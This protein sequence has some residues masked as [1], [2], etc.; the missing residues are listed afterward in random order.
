VTSELFAKQS[1]ERWDLQNAAVRLEGGADRADD[2]AWFRVTGDLELVF[3]SD[4]V[5]GTEFLLFELGVL[6]YYDVG[7]YLAAA[8]I[9]DM[10]AMGAKPIALTSVIRYPRTL[11]DS[12]FAEILRGI[13]DCC[14]LHGCKNVGGDIGTA[15]RVILS[16]SA[17]GMTRPGHTLTRSG[18]RPGD[19]VLL[20]APTGV[21]LAAMIYFDGKSKYG[22]KLE[23]RHEDHL[24]AAWKRVSP[25]TKLGAFLSEKKLATSCQDTSDGL[26]ATV[27]QIE[28][29]SMVSL[30]IDMDRVP[31]AESVQ[32]VASLADLPVM[33]IVFGGS[34]DFRLL[35]T[36]PQPDVRLIPSPA[37]VIGYV[38][39]SPA[40]GEVLP[41][42]TWKHQI[43]PLAGYRRSLGAAHAEA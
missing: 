7:F 18:A 43:D 27:E 14:S 9:S 32:A 10:A 38:E 4:Y 30:R 8:N 11:S 19:V 3:A 36:V 26:R 42:S 13:R 39:S 17:I 20:S 31:V 15:E 28:T 5:R 29:A 6:N 40:S 12:E 23:Q 34:V 2:A 22:W 1:G 25:E 24:S 21:A 33:D 16:A 35:F 37:T 41:G